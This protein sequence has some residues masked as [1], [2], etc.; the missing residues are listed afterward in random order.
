MNSP[1]AGPN[2]ERLLQLLKERPHV[3]LLI[4][5]GYDGYFRAPSLD[6]LLRA[7]R[8]EADA[9][10][11]RDQQTDLQIERLI[12]AGLNPFAYRY[13]DHLRRFGDVMKIS[14]PLVWCDWLEEGGV[15]SPRSLIEGVLVPPWNDS[16]FQFWPELYLPGWYEAQNQHQPWRPEEKRLLCRGLRLEFYS[17]RPV[18]LV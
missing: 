7:Y 6:I 4:Q 12:E 9:L 8:K 15:R 10:L 13:Q 14:D 2:R 16:E 1:S 17:L 3:T 5:N 11:E 18:E